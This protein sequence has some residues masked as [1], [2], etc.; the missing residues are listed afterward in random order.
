MP[1]RARQPWPPCRTVRWRCE[2][3]ARCI[4]GRGGAVLHSAV[5]A[6]QGGAGWGGVVLYVQCSAVQCSAARYG[7]V[8]C[9]TCSAAPCRAVP[10]GRCSAVPCMPCVRCCALHV[11]PRV[12]YPPCGAVRWLRAHTHVCVCVRAHV[13]SHVC[14]HLHASKRASVCPCMRG[15]STRRFGPYPRTMLVVCAD[16]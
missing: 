6:V 1:C 14:S 15:V 11:V 12:W 3:V 5:C 10:Y 16:S 4:S 2:A 9:L 7:A 8:Q 13:C